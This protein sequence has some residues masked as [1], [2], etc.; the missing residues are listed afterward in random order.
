[1][2]ISLQFALSFRRFYWW[3][4]RPITRGARAIVV[5]EKGE[6]LL[7]RHRYDDGWFLPGG[8][9]RKSESDEDALRRELKEELGITFTAQEKLG[10]YLN[11]YEYKKD[12]IVVFVIRS[13]A[14]DERH[15]FEIGAWQFFDPRALPED[16]SPG[17]RRRIEEWLNQRT[18][19][20][21]W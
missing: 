10:E 3:L 4:V 16:V 15:H 19:S 5:N 14:L 8:K 13:F 9:A 2:N 12:M 6:V 17:T 11:T 21:Q 1:M 7:V 18:I 20:G